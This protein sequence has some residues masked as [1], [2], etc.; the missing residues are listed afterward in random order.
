MAKK[1]KSPQYSAGQLLVCTIAQEEPGG[2]NVTLPNDDRE[3]FLP[4]HFELKIGEKVEACFVCE[5]R[6]RLLL[7]MSP[8]EMKKERKRLETEKPSFEGWKTFSAKVTPVGKQLHGILKDLEELQAD[9][10]DSNPLSKRLAAIVKQ[11][12]QAIESLEHENEVNRRRVEGA[13][14]DSDLQ[15]QIQRVEQYKPKYPHDPHR[16]EGK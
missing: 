6:T 12:N 4:S 11:L 14:L 13:I 9:L 2:Y 5:Q 7:A 8:E 16:I 10:N 15:R 3:A 1:K